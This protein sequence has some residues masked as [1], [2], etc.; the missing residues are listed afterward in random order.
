MACHLNLDSTSGLH[1]NKS[2]L[3]HTNIQCTYYISNLAK[4][5][6]ASSNILYKFQ[7]KAASILGNLNKSKQTKAKISDAFVSI[8]PFLLLFLTSIPLVTP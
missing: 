3:R 8:T 2:F 6:N 5:L 1:K 4:K 7:F